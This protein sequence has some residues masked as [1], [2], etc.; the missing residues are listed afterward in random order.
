LEPEPSLPPKH[1]K[2]AQEKFIMEVINVLDTIVSP[3]EWLIPQSQSFLKTITSEQMKRRVRAIVLFLSVLLVL[4][5]V[6]MVKTIQISL[7]VALQEFESALQDQSPVE[8]SICDSEGD[9]IQVDE[10]E[11]AIAHLLQTHLEDCRFQDE[12]QEWLDNLR[13][14][15]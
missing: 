4:F 12:I 8:I 1:F 2:W 14:R 6:G 15:V 13:F 10:V 9:R 5:L 11:R 3:I 7:Q